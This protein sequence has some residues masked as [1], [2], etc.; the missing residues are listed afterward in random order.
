MRR[1]LPVT[2][3]RKPYAALGSALLGR[4]VFAGDDPTGY[5]IEVQNWNLPRGQANRNMTVPGVAFFE[6][7]SGEGSIRTGGQNTDLK[8]GSAL[9]GL[10]RTAI[11]SKQ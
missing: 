3:R 5:G 4:T 8:L 9:L 11:R 7:R 1:T 2:N 10:S 6:V